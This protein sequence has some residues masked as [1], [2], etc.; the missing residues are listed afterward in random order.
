MS[1]FSVLS[2]IVNFKLETVE[3]DRNVTEIRFKRG[4]SHMDFARSEGTLNH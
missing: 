2:I 3:K 1:V 4:K